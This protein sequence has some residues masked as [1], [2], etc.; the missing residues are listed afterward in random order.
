MRLVEQTTASWEFWFGLL[1]QFVERNGHACPLV[2]FKVDGYPLGEW[3]STQRD[4]KGNGTLDADRERRLKELTGW[5]WDPRADKWEEGFRRLLDYVERTRSRPHR[6][7]FQGRRLPA[8]RVGQ[9]ATQY[10]LTRGILDADR[11]SRLKGVPGW[12]WDPRADK[13]EEGF[14]RLLDYVKRTR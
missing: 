13:W 1:E 12:T 7:A 3:V 6:A 8:R 9:H 14:S 2:S 11:Q 5:T 4:R 10:S